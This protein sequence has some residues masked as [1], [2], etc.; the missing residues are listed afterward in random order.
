MFYSHA[1][2][3]KSPKVPKDLPPD[4]GLEVDPGRAIT[5]S[6]SVPG[7]EAWHFEAEYRPANGAGW[8]LGRIE[9]YPSARDVVNGRPVFGRPPLPGVTT[10]VLRAIP[11]G[12]LPDWLGAIHLEDGQR[13]I[14]L[15]TGASV[16]D[17]KRRPRP[18]AAGRDDRPFAELAREYLDACATSRSPIRDLAERHSTNEHTIRDRLVQARKR[19]LLES[20]GR[21]RPGGRLTEKGR[22]ALAPEEGQR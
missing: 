11:L 1:M 4:L 9:V 22:E 20:A 13:L 17:F 7:H 2:P 12:R 14:P 19:G 8:V 18:G 6:A 3:S 21:G 10:N 16:V 15:V 5:L